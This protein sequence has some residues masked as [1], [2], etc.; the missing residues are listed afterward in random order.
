VRFY[1]ESELRDALLVD[2]EGLIYG[3]VQGVKFAESGAAIVAYVEFKARRR[4][5]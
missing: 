4:C 3:R 2:S 5:E 1:L